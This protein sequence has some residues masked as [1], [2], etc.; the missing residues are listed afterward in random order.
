[1][2]TVTQGLGKVSV[3][4]RCW[5][6]EMAKTRARE[7]MGTRTWCWQREEIRPIGFSTL[8]LLPTASIAM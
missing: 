4:V 3:V 6:H 5:V 2:W 1:M 7:W 8:T